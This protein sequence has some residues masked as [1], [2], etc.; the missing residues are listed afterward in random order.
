[1]LET[2]CMYHKGVEAKKSASIIAFL[3]RAHGA[4]HGASTAVC[5]GGLCNSQCDGGENVIKIH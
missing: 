3:Y 1:M 2:H 4:Y 5:N